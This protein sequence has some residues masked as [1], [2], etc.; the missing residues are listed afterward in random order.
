MIKSLLL[1][2]TVMCCTTFGFSQSVISP[3]K[4]AQAQEFN[5][6]LNLK[7]TISQQAMGQAIDFNV[8][9]TG[10]HRFRVTNA[11]D[12][13][14][15]LHHDVNRLR[16]NFDG[17][18][19]KRSFDSNEE[20]DMKGPFGPY[21]REILDKQYHIIIDPQGQTLMVMP[22]SIAIKVEDPRIALINAMLKDVVEIALPPAK[23]EPGFFHP[24]ANDSLKTGLT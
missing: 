14:T 8:D 16:F 2:L 20:T 7:T 5:I 15:T 1:S 4:F 9:A 10:D 17:M 24:F 23:D 22:E 12:D 6:N 18:G 13:N 19:Q 3:L 21:A 11:T